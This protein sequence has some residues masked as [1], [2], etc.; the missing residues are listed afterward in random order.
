MQIALLC[1]EIVLGSLVQGVL[2]SGTELGAQLHSPASGA[3]T[4]QVRLGG[5][6]DTVVV[7]PLVQMAGYPLPTPEAVDDSIH[8]S[9]TEKHHHV[10]D[11][12]L[13]VEWNGYPGHAT[14]IVAG[15]AKHCALWVPSNGFWPIVASMRGGTR[16]LLPRRGVD[17]VRELTAIRANHAP[18]HFRN[19]NEKWGTPRR[20]F[21]FHLSSAPPGRFAMEG[22]A[23]HPF[24]V[25]F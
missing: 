11:H 23:F 9:S 2:G 18:S 22:T 3:T 5:K 17:L 14:A 13:R 8:R 15:I 10:F 7:L 4:W 20:P 1:F 19:A 16:A 21:P 24:A 6:R 25:A 12:T